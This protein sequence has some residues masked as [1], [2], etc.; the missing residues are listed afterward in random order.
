MRPLLIEKN[1]ASIKSGR[2]SA[3]MH[4]H[5]SMKLELCALPRLPTHP[6]DPLS[7]KIFNVSTNFIEN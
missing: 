7:L 1:T 5:H 2:G 4:T 6:I 3:F